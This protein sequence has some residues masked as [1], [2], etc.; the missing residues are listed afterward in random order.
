MVFEDGVCS[1]GGVLSFWNGSGPSMYGVVL[2][3]ILTTHLLLAL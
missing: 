1:N 3:A 2:L